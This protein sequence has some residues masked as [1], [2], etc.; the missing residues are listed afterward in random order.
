MQ[1]YERLYWYIHEY[2]RLVYDY[3]SKDAVAFLVT[4]YN[5]NV[6]QTVWED[7]DIFGGAYEKT[8]DL[9]GIKRNKILLL[10]VYFIE[11]ITTAFDGQDTGYNKD[12]TTSFVIPST[13]NYIPYPNDIIKLEQAY[14]RPTNDVYPLYIVTGV[15][16]SV[17]TDKR[18]WKLRVEV[19]QSETLSA[20]EAQ[21]ENMYSFV[22]YDKNI[23][24]IEDAEL[25]TKLLIK[26]EK[27]KNNLKP[28][29]DS[30][31]GFYFMGEDGLIERSSSS[32]SSM[33]SSSN[34]SSSSS[35]SLS[36]SSNSYS[37]SSKSSSSSSSE[38]AH[39]EF[40]GD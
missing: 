10:P 35:F 34:S 23:H 11:D 24:E 7:Q 12:N 33:S 9:S 39:F 18:F 13:Y 32:S 1:N 3:Y 38:E 30:N 6:S 2:Q 19:F 14:L 22:D 16:A 20:V 40:N 17:N 28:L 27:I 26:E 36:V 31:S 25:I 4:Y 5:L 29:F 37:F 21:V 8:G 15:E